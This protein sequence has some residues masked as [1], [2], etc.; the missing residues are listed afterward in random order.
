[1]VEF[2]DQLHRPFERVN[3]AVTMVANVHHPSTGRT[4]TVENIEFPQ[5]EI[6]IRWP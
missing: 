5:S 4:S 1:M 2:A 3:A 6:G